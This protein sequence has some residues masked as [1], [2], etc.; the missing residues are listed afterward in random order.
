MAEP[1]LSSRPPME[2][3]RSGEGAAAYRKKHRASLS[4][5]IA[6]WREQRLLR[7][8]LA[9]IAPVESVLDCPCG[10][11]RFVPSIAVHAKTVWA[12]DVS[13][14]M[15][16][17]AKES[18]AAARFAVC[19]AGHLPLPDGSVDVA[20]CCRLVHHL[21]PEE[22]IA[23]LTEAARVA[24]R[25]VIVSFADADTWKGRRMTSRRRPIPRA[26]LEQEATAAG[27]TVESPYLSVGGLFSCFSFALLRRAREAPD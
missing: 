18:G 11:G 2:R 22:R 3:Y 20:V 21:S 17:E 7:R 15:V 25:A 14:P 13:E 8:M 5:R 16:H 19:D 4:R 26:Q 9:R 23:L 24:R 27:M 1:I 6:S 12:F 10:A